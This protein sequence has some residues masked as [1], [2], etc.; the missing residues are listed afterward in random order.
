MTILERSPSTISISVFLTSSR[1]TTFTLSN[2]W[3]LT[4]SPLGP[5][6]S[7]YVVLA[8]TLQRPSHEF[9]IPYAQR[10]CPM[11]FGGADPYTYIEFWR[12][13][14]VFL[15]PILQLFAHNELNH[16]QDSGETT[17]FDK[18]LSLCPLKL[19]SASRPTSQTEK[20]SCKTA[21]E[22]WSRLSRTTHF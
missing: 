10:F 22:L 2:F 12:W 18:Y 17:S 16:L 13:R 21:L 7:L 9:H 20:A 6:G 3:P 11:E 15:C 8:A 19:A 1:W 14:H 4:R 5:N